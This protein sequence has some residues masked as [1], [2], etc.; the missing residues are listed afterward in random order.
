MESSFSYAVNHEAL[1]VS[2][3]VTRLDC[4]FDG[5]RSFEDLKFWSSFQV[6][7]NLIFNL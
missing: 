3:R 1:T 2:Q 6:L 4:E 7:K 5:R